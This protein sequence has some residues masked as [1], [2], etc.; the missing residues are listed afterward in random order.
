VTISQTWLIYFILLRLV[1]LKQMWWGFVRSYH[2]D[3]IT[4]RC[5]E[6]DYSVI[7][8]AWSKTHLHALLHNEFILIFVYWAQST[9][10]NC[11]KE[12]RDIYVLLLYC[13]NKIY[14]NTGC[15]IVIAQYNCYLLVVIGARLTP[16]KLTQFVYAVRL[17]CRLPA[18]G[19][20]GL[21]CCVLIGGVVTGRTFQ[22]LAG[23]G[24]LTQ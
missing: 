14:R 16:Q 10:R 13:A 5:P 9:E 24:F 2:C 22:V 1:Y 8:W 7:K 21:Q 18:A 15:T 17:E 3:V 19:C 6:R 11:Y 20:L 12:L 23:F 4:A